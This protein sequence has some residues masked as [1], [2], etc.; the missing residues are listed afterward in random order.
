M[1]SLEKMQTLID[2]QKRGNIA[3]ITMLDGDSILCKLHN[4]A[5]DEEDWAYDVVTIEANPKHYTLECG[6]IKSIEE[7]T[8]GIYDEINRVAG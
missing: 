5:E 7:L 1:T 3:K 6:F 4:P 2:I 8:I